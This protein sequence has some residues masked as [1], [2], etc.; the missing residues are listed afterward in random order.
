MADKQRSPTAPES[1]VW[2]FAYG[3]IMWNPGFAYAESA[4]ALLRGWHRAFCIYSYRYRGTPEKPGL[5]L[6][7]DRGGS[8]RGVV[9]RLPDD[10]APAI[11]EQC[12]ARELVTGVYIRRP[13]TVATSAGPVTC[14]AYVT[15]RKHRQYAGKLDEAEKARLIAQGVNA[16]GAKNVEYLENTLRHLAD[17]GIDDPYLR[18]LWTRVEKRHEL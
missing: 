5:V 11:V 13:V 2:L 7:L 18:R 17:L 3:S 6:G 1:G 12:D 16:S 8:C 15:D 10:A 14:W 9:F 4:P